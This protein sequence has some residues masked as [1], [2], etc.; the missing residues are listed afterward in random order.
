MNTDDLLS[1]LPSVEESPKNLFTRKT[2]STSFREKFNSYGAATAAVT[3][4]TGSC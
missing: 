4:T 3:L 1:P 2:N